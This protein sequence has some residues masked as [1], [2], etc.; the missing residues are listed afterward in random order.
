MGSALELKLL[1]IGSPTAG[2][3]TSTINDNW[4]LQFALNIDL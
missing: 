1:S 4:T 3:I 2:R